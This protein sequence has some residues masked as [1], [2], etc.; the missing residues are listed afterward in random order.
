MH[1]HVVGNFRDRKVV[2]RQVFLTLAEAL[3]AAGLSE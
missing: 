3:E 2:R 1:V